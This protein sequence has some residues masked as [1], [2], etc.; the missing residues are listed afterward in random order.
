VLISHQAITGH[1]RQLRGQ[2]WNHLCILSPALWKPVARVNAAELFF[3]RSSAQFFLGECTHF[4][5]G[6]G[7][8]PDFDARLVVAEAVEIEIRLLRQ[9]LLE[10][11]L[12]LISLIV[13]VVMGIPDASAPAAMPVV[14]EIVGLLVVGAVEGEGG[15]RRSGATDVAICFLIWEQGL[16]NVMATGVFRKIEDNRVLF[17]KCSAYSRRLDLHHMFNI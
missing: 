13:V 16:N 9:L 11:P 7:T 5:A 17:A 3:I 2:I 15:R 10:E 4:A 6:A 12:D 8:A 14:M 1:L